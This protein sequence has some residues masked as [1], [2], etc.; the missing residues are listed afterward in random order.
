MSGN[1][2][3]T[4]PIQRL[5]LPQGHGGFNVANITLYADLFLMRQIQKYCKHR[6]E[7]T[8]TTPNVALIEFN[9]GQEISNLFQLRQINYFP[10][11][12]RPS[13]TYAYILAIIKKCHFTFEQLC[14]NNIARIYKIITQ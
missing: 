1:S 11:A 12:T 9:I 13:I 6:A 7:E 3:I 10:H 8:P 4:I 2:K 5:A 14:K